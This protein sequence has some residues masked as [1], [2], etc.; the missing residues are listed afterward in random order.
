MDVARLEAEIV[1]LMAETQK[2]NRR[3]RWVPF[4]QAGGL[5]LAVMAASKFLIH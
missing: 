2:L 4:V 5:I 3:P 1:K